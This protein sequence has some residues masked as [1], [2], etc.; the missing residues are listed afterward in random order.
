MTAY[1]NSASSAVPE[2]VLRGGQQ[3]KTALQQ[4]IEAA[5][6]GQKTPEQALADAAAE[7]D[8][9]WLRTSNSSH[10]KRRDA[11]ER[12]EQRISQL[13]LASHRELIS[14]LLSFSASLRLCVSY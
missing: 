9:S 3:M 10:A 12:R 13:E 1:V 7:A 8:A 6:Y 14:V 5:W 4:G 11:K 2:P